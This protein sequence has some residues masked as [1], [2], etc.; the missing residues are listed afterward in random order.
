MNIPK[1]H[2]AEVLLERPEVY[3]PPMLDEI[4]EFT[5]LTR[6]DS[7]GLI[8]EEFGYYSE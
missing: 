6:A 4:G 8:A 2:D 7:V 3:Q 5:A 1:E